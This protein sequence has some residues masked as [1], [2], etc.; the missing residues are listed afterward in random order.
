[1]SLKRLRAAPYCNHYLSLSK[2][3]FQ[4]RNRPEPKKIDQHSK[5]IIYRPVFC[6]HKFKNML[7]KS[8]GLE[9]S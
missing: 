3:A 5:I 6:Y 2:A 7:L 9:E 4:G 8:Y 1:L